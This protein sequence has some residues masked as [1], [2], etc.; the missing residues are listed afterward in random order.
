[1]RLAH[2]TST[3]AAL[4]R[5]ARLIVV[6]PYPLWGQTAVVPAIAWP[7]PGWIGGASCGA[8]GG[9][10]A[11]PTMLSAGVGRRPP[12]SRTVKPS[13]AGRRAMSMLVNW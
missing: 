10:L 11:V 1:M 2:A 9:G 5:G 3:I 6:D 13:A 7:V 12:R 4:R 8:Q